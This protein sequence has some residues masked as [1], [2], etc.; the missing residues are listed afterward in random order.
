M[1]DDQCHCGGADH[2]PDRR[3]DCQKMKTPAEMWEQYRDFVY[4]AEL[5][6]GEENERKQAFFAGAESVFKV[7]E[8]GWIWTPEALQQYREAIKAAALETLPPEDRLIIELEQ[9][10]ALGEID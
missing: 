1:N 6:E 4:E 5:P 8:D 7:L 3:P 9:K 10:S 2:H